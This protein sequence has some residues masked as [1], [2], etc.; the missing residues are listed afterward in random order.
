MSRPIA[1]AFV[2]LLLSVAIT[3]EFYISLIGFIN[4][5]GL[6]SLHHIAMLAIE[7]NHIWLPTLHAG[8]LLRQKIF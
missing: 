3:R 4:G 6:K 2:L 7:Y 5:L 1:R 8:A